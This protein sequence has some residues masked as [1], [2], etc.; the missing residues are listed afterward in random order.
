RKNISLLPV[1]VGQAS[2]GDMINALEF[3]PD[4]EV[5]ITASADHTACVW[6]VRDGKQR[7]C[8]DSPGAVK[9]A[10]FTLDGDLIV[11]GDETGE[12]L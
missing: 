4:G 7:F 1:P 5:F 6:Q 11:T 8:V 3:S 2:Q 9:D 12:I 10:T